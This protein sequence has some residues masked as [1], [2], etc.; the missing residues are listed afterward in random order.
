MQE[1]LIDWFDPHN[2][3]HLRAWRFLQESGSWP[4]G[5]LP[6]NL[7]ISRL[8]HVELTHQMAECWLEYALHD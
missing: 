6:D 5:F 8:W 2:P 1:S 3:E 4:S 7:Y